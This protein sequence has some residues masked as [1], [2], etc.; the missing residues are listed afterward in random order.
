MSQDEE[1]KKAVLAELNWEP[2]IVAAHIGV[3]AEAGTVTLTGHVESFGQKHAAEM[4]TGRVKGV[5]AVAEE[6]EVRLPYTIK[7]DD[8]QIATAAVDRLMW[9]AQTPRD[10]V[11][12]KVEKGW[13]TLTGAVNWHFEKE[14]AEREVRGLMGVVGVTNQITIKPHVDTAHVSEDIRHALHRGWFDPH[15]INVTEHDGKVKLTG[16]VGNWQDRQTAGA[17]A[18]A[19]PGTTSVENDLIVTW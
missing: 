3:T 2:S 18:W 9:D 14:A 19:A 10:S 5:K 12:V 15:K 13:L 7:R 6:I 4:A 11:K 1:L 17:T 16:S 8:A